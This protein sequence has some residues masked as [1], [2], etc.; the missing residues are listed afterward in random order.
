MS[1]NSKIEREGKNGF[2]GKEKKV[3]LEM[4]GMEMK[5][6]KGKGGGG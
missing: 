2:N 6:K 4:V 5:D 1:E 3:M